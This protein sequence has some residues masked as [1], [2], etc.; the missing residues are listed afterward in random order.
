MNC[1]RRTRITTGLNM[2]LYRLFDIEAK[3]EGFFI[4][5]GFACQHFLFCHLCP[6][7]GTQTCTHTVTR[8]H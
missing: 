5:Y 7:H 6:N 1:W 4:D 2:N 3:A 8:T